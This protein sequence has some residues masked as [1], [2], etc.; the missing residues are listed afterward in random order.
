MP[1]S[2]ML[3]RLT[4]DSLTIIASY[5]AVIELHICVTHHKAPTSTSLPRWDDDLF[6]TQDFLRRFGS[7][8]HP[9]PWHVRTSPLNN[10]WTVFFYTSHLDLAAFLRFAAISRSWVKPMAQLSLHVPVINVRMMP[11]FS[12]MLNTDFE[13]H[14]STH[15]QSFFGVGLEISRFDYQLL[16]RLRSQHLRAPEIFR[17]CTQPMGCPAQRDVCVCVDHLFAKVSASFFKKNCRGATP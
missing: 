2:T 3:N 7:Y 16:P 1:L 15:K 10:S 8:N 12:Y 13:W 17:F 6:R 5:V 14:K 9:L 11:K 4:P